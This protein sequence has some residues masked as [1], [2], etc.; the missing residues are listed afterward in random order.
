MKPL[1]IPFFISHQGC[2]HQCVFCDQERIS[3]QSAG[4]PEPSGMVGTID[5]FAAS[6]GGRPLEVAFYGGTFTSLP[7][8]EQERLLEPLQPLL[9]TGR[10]THVRLSTRPDA[11]DGETAR[12]LRARGVTTVELGVQSMDDRVLEAAGRGHTAAHVEQAFTGLR[13]AGIRV[14]AQLMPGLP[15]DTSESPLGSLERVL[16][17]SPAFLRIYPT[18]V[19]AGTR[20]ADL[21]RNGAYAPLGLDDAVT[22]CA[23]MLRRCLVA[24]VPV[25]RIG[26]QPTEE[27]E[28]P[29]TVLAGPWHPAFRQLVE[30]ELFYGLLERL[31]AGVPPGTSVEAVC[32]P[33]RVSDVVGQ[34]RRNL[35]RLGEQHGVSVTR[36]TGSDRLSPYDLEIVYAGGT[37][38]GNLVGA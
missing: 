33:Q 13:E 27:L 17:L 12:F 29:G 9:A 6:G 8:M 10:I 34:R 15:G 31:A 2:P 37:I 18:V 35:A 11:V 30:S 3:G 28:R 22:L 19:V 38:A 26:L 1:I 16:A 5:R 21:W 14:G 25:I 36:V 20:L 4:L 7:R 32:A 24:G 23:A